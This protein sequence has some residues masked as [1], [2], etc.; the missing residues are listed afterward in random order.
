MAGLA[1]SMS[2]SQLIFEQN[3]MNLLVQM[4]YV[5]LCTKMTTNMELQMSRNEV[6]PEDI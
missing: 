2:C 3:S 4:N 6:V 5:F 1:V